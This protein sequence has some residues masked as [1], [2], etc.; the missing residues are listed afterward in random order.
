M[1]SPSE[2]KVNKWDF[3]DLTTAEGRTLIRNLIANMSTP[4]ELD[5]LAAAVAGKM[6]REPDGAPLL[7]QGRQLLRSIDVRRTKIR[8]IDDPE[9]INLRRPALPDPAQML[10]VKTKRDERRAAKSAAEA[11]TVSPP[12][13]KGASPDTTVAISSSPLT[14]AVDQ[15]A[16]V[17]VEI[18]HP[19]LKGTFNLR[20]QAERAI[21]ISI[22]GSSVDRWLKKYE[23]TF[24][25]AVSGLPNGESE[26]ADVR[27][28]LADRATEL[29]KPPPP[30]ATTDQLKGYTDLTEW[31]KKSVLPLYGS[32]LM[33][34]VELASVPSRSGE[35]ANNRAAN[36]N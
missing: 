5:E 31:S 27:K 36:I 1:K 2:P 28:A 32:T 10:L 21:F 8:D 19:K 14:T 20:D 33:K 6:R 18:T 9:R 17:V 26:F 13:N 7:A 30:P 16:A 34:R 24:A 25:A 15:A 29:A 11:E 3:V 35:E 23:A 4:A 12:A 22:I